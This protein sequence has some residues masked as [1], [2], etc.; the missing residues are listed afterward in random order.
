MRVSRFRPALA[1]ALLL[2]AC[3][4]GTQSDA[5]GITPT[6]AQALND[7]AEML[8][9]NAVQIDADDSPAPLENDR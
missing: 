1:C 2:S 6:E 4:G 8:D 3:G 9:A 7:A 5:S